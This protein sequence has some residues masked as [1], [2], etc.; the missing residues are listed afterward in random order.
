[1]QIEAGLRAR[2][3]PDPIADLLQIS[4][5]DLGDFGIVLDQQH[6]AGRG[7][8]AV[9]HP[10]SRGCAGLSQVRGK[11]NVTAVP[12]RDDVAMQA[13]PPDWRAKP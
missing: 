1:M 11:N 7:A 5:A 12:R 3:V 2:R 9:A 10:C 8:C 6:G 13:A 4:L